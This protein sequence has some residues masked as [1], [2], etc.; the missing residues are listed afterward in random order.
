MITA[1]YS[2]P[3][4][5]AGVLLVSVDGKNKK[6]LLIGWKILQTAVSTSSQKSGKKASTKV[7]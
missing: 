2:H 7:E 4:T 5:I 6:G 3:R 1:D